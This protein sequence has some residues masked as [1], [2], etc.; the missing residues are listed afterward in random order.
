MKI[1]KRLV[2]AMSILV[3]GTTAAEA[4]PIEIG[5]PVPDLVLPTLDGQPK[6]LA[7]FRGQ[8][9]LLHIFASW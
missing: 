5:K 3:F 2:I 8:K 4:A 9:V 1:M 6:S 7:D